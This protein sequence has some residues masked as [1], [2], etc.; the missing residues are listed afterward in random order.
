MGISLIIYITELIILAVVIIVGL[1]FLKIKHKKGFLKFQG[2]VLGIFILIFGVTFVFEKPEIELPKEETIQVEVGANNKIQLPKTK[3]HFNDVTQ[4]VRI[5]GNIDYSKIGEYD[6]TLELDTLFGKYSQSAKVKVVDITAPE[7]TLEGEEY[8]NQSYAKEY[9]EPGFKASDE[10]DGELTEKV[11]CKK[12]N[13]DETHYKIIYSVEDSSGNK[14]EKIRNVTIIDDVAPIIDLNGEATM[15][16]TPNSNYE[17]KGAK[18]QDEKDGDLTENIKTEGTVDTS[19]EGTYTITYKVS[20]KSGNEAVAK[21]TV[22]VKQYIA[23]DQSQNGGTAGTIYLTFDDGP[24]TNITPQILDILA[25][26]GVK[27]TFFILNYNSAG[28]ALVQREYNEGHSVAIHGYSHDYKQIYQSEQAYMNN[29]IQLQDK[30]KA[31]TGYTATI[32]RFP[33]GSSNTVSR[34][35]PGIMTRLCKL[36]QER[37]FRYFDWNVDSN[38]AGGARNS[39]EVYNNVIKSL[40]KSRANVVLMHDFS[41]NQKGADALARI[42][43]YGIANGYTFSRITESTPMVTHTPNN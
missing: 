19:K 10:Y 4:K 22:L 34:F 41:S 23:P 12:E 39:D 43:D 37:G 14:T 27:A 38:D 26:K 13:I 40:S 24:T 31:S 8:F 36:I 1:I 20:D 33:G 18:A 9:Q 17:E 32:T 30:I 15:Q 29:L 6:I 42:I 11:I 16:L 28:E 35:N 7:I 3:Y 2:I 21:R 5:N 25:S